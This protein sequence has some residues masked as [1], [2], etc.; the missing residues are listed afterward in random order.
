MW[1]FIFTQSPNKCQYQKEFLGKLIIFPFII[2]FCLIHPPPPPF[3]RS[4]IHPARHL[5]SIT[6]HSLIHSFI[7]SP[8]HSFNAIPHP[9][10][11]SKLILCPPRIPAIFCCCWWKLR[12][13]L[14]PN[15]VVILS[16][17]LHLE[18]SHFPF[19]VLVSLL[20]F[21]A[22]KMKCH[23]YILFISS[24]LGSV[25]CPFY[26]IISIC[27]RGTTYTAPPPSPSSSSAHMMI[28]AFSHFIY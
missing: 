13:F 28:H 23:S 16:H 15:I 17:H 24:A 14:P 19:R 25:L 6:P 11:E 8:I 4:S 2:Y 9:T 21:S 26:D 18:F 1:A 3:T 27:I 10:V 5:H 22:L 12:I 20:E 7:H